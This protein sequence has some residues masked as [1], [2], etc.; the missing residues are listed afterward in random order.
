MST[1]KKFATLLS[2]TS[3]MAV[4][5]FAQGLETTASRDDWEEINFEFNSN[6]LVDG[7][8]SLL[9][10]AELLRSNPNYRVTVEGHADYIGSNRYNERLG[11]RRAQTVQQFLVKYGANANQVTVQTRGERN[12]KVPSRT[13]D[14]RFMNRRVVFT[15]TDA[16][17]NP[18]KDGR[19]QAVEPG[20]GIADVIKRLDA[21]Q[22]GQDAM[23]DA[24]LKRLDRLD[25]IAGLLEKLAGQNSELQ[26]RVQALEAQTTKVSETVQTLPNRQ[27]TATI[28][29]TR[30]E[31]NRDR[32]YGTVNF[33]AGS[34]DLRGI[35]LQGRGR[36][37]AP[38]KDRIGIQASGEYMYY[39][40]HQEGQGDVGV[41]A[42]AGAFQ[43]GF[44]TSFKYVQLRGRNDKL[45]GGGPLLADAASNSMFGM[46][47]GG[48]LLG[49]FAFLGDFIF[50]RGKVGGFATRR[51]LDGAT[52]GRVGVSQVL[53]NVRLVS[54]NVF[55]EAYLGVVNQYGASATVGLWGDSYFEGNF[56]A[57]KSRLDTTRPG[58]TARLVLPVSDRFAFTVEGGLNETFLGRTNYTRLLG[59]IQV[60]NFIRPRE[61]ATINTP[62]P[63]DI[64]RVRFEVLT[65]RVREG[66]GTPVA[67]AGGDRVGIPAGTVTLDGSRSFDPDGDALTY[68]WEQLSGPSVALTGANTA[69]ATFTAAA[70]QTYSFRLTVTDTQG[71]QGIDRAS[72]TTAIG[73]QPVRIL[74]FTATPSTIVSGNTSTL[75]YAVENAESVTIDGIGQVDPRG[76]SIVVSPTTTTTYRLTA[77]GGN[78]EESRS[79]T[80]TV[81]QPPTVAPSFT[82]CAITP[83]T[84]NAGQSATISYATQNATSVTISP[85][86]GNVGQ[87]G[88]ITVTP[89]QN[90]TYTLTATGGGGQTA[91]CTLSLTVNQGPVTPPPTVVSF[92]ANP[93]VITRGQSSTLTYNVEGADT[94]TISGVGAV[95]G[96]SGSVP[97]T[98]TQTTTYT[99]T[100][101]NAGGEVTRTA[102]V[103]VNDA[104]V[105][106]QPSL[107]ACAATPAT[108]PRPGDPVVLSFTA[109]NATAVTISPGIGNVPVAGGVTVRPAQTTTYVVT[110][111]GG[112]GTTAA[113][114][115]IVVT[116]TPAPVIPP[117]TVV[118]A[119]P[120]SFDTD[121]REIV[122]DASQTTDTSAGQLLYDWSTTGTGVAILDQGQPRTRIQFPEQQG[123][124][125]IVRLRVTNVQTGQVGQAEVQI[126][127]L[128]TLAR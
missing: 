19:G 102:T 8:P 101:R 69:V 26:K 100:A 83:G 23:R 46:A 108:S 40:S 2:L 88:S 107:T 3:L 9:R 54:T 34:D 77:R 86:V 50:P 41:V 105:N 122:I 120:A 80:V 117:P 61:F 57:L 98:P 5:S 103:T 112:A 126:R 31:A 87:N 65:R 104:P 22:Q 99:L 4:V 53:N 125:F 28:V 52:V 62:V 124:T 127:Y 79:V 11:Q 78:T 29:D 96:P 116:V 36:F 43:A 58:G 70:G 111:T 7:Y 68:R 59:G 71:S 17:G 119:G 84:I 72:I 128:P 109:T 37:F 81:T 44:F 48:G 33:A 95:Q 13:R 85:G 45:P 51:F 56:G 94:I 60:G 93:T 110:A 25:D 27:E 24:L 123:G 113:T 63:M 115:N 12:P 1:L 16:Q 10:L 15:L 118:I 49:Q 114:C 75:V 121:R 42:R 82:A 67:D 73:T 30:L 35:T 47:S 66:N 6:V 21:L 92:T 32:R 20:L 106:P 14:G 74:N 64:P 91:T 76:G 18:I 90:T 39:R 55:D 97:V 89:S 38:Y